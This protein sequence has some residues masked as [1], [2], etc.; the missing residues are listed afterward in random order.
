MLYLH[1]VPLTAHSQAWRVGKAPKWS[2]KASK[3]QK[4]AGFSVNKCPN[5]TETRK[6]TVRVSSFEFLSALKLSESGWILVVQVLD[7]DEFL[8]TQVSKFDWV[9]RTNDCYDERPR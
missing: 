2:D 9:A 1:F 6:L 7:C 5:L 3:Y 8:G 4:L